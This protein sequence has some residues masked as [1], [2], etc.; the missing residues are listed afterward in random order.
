MSGEFVHCPLCGEELRERSMD[1]CPRTVCPSCGFVHYRN[2]APAV[3][4]LLF[5]NGRILLVKRRFEPYRGLWVIPSGFMEYEETVTE[6]AV[7]EIKE[8]TGLDVEMEELHSVVSCFDD[9]R[10][11]TLLVLYTGRITGGSLEP[12][13]DAEDAAFFPLDGL[14]AV[15]FEAHRRVLGSL[16]GS[17]GGE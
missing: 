7:R 12:G 5:E 11:N 1:G 3:G 16:V 8:E 10:G 4:V 9:P 6:C 15:A 17:V 13:D 2:P 14:P